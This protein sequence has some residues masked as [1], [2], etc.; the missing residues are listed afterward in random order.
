MAD[1]DQVIDRAGIGDDQ[2]HGLQP[3]VSESLPFLFEIF[4]R[5]VLVDAMGFKEAI[6]LDAGEAEH[7]AQF[8]FGDAPRPERFEGDAFQRHARESPPASIRERPMSSGI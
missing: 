2:A 3:E 1:L 8:N 6:Q 4:E 7:L 5:V